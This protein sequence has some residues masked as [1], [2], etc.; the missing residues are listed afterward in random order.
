MSEFFAERAARPRVKPVPPWEQDRNERIDRLLAKELAWFVVLVP[1]QKELCVER[2]FT[3]CGWDVLVPLQYRYRRVNSRQKTKRLM[4]YVMASR[5]VFV[6]IPKTEPFPWSKF[7]RMQLVSG[8]MSVDGLP[9]TIPA[10]TMRGLWSRMRERD[11]KPGTSK[12][13]LNRGIEVGDYVKI[14]SG[15]FKDFEVRIDGIE[16]GRA[17]VVVGIFGSATPA[18]VSIDELEPV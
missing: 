16:S 8:L 6:G 3:L 4:A 2:V 9:V 11:G 17:Q 12:V 15:P 7:L 14:A 13:R 10:E 18:E 1:P 5:Y